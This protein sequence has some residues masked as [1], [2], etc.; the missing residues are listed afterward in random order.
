MVPIASLHHGRPSYAGLI[1]HIELTPTEYADWI[2]SPFV[3]DEIAGD[4]PIRLL[5]IRGDA[6]DLPSPG[7]LPVVVASLTPLD[8]ADLVI[9][10]DQLDGLISAV[11]HSPIAATSLAVLLRIIESVD[12]EA[13][14][15]IESAV[16]ST[17]QAGPE[18]AAWRATAP[19]QSQHDV[20]PTVSIERNEGCLA[21]ALNRP[22][23]H[24]AINARL[25]DELCAALAIAIA[26]DTITSVE[27]RGNGSS[28]CSGG[29]L[30]EF[31]A[32]SDPATAHTIRLARSPA[33]LIHRLNDRITVHIHGSTLG[34][35]IEMAAFAG[36]VVAHPDTVI[37]LPEVSL[38]LIP[39]AGGTVSLTKRIGRQRTAYLALTG[40]SISAATALKWH[41]IDA[42]ECDVS[43][44]RGAAWRP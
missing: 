4:D 29:D 23:R 6:S 10:D 27:L 8:V 11:T 18:F 9:E 22:D 17:L 14:L 26:D 24:N 2:R 7:S 34:G 25:R 38:G 42:I 41:L 1:R 32:R 28:F 19:H 15:A 16:Y 39:G 21:L 33:R 37:A 35:G 12:V 5:V 20:G 13:G 44:W 40:Q 43:R 30:G 31:G 3:D 36:H